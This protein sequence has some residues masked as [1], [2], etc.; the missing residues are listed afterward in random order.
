MKETIIK[1]L[2]PVINKFADELI[3]EKKK[4]IS[5]QESL[6]SEILKVKEVEKILKGER[7]DD[8]KRV[9]LEITKLNIE[10]DKQNAL[11][12]NLSQEI[13]KYEALQKTLSVKIKTVQ[14]NVNS[15]EMGRDLVQ[16]ELERAKEKTKEYEL[17][18]NHLKRDFDELDNKR[19]ELSNEQRQINSKLKDVRIRED[20]IVTDAILLTEREEKLKIDIRKF[21]FQKSKYGGK[22]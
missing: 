20:K 19:R 12:K 7:Q 22:K 13:S 11:N 16:K 3:V 9:A 6:D 2:Q 5:L 4:V 15:S 21:N 14:V 17:K 10:K 18:T 8:K 1:N